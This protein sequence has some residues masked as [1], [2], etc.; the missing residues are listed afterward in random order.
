MSTFKVWVHIEEIDD[1][2][3]PK[4]DVGLPEFLGDFDELEDA[5]SFVS[6][7]FDEKT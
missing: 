6:L 1:D 3:E 7:L 2:G 5:E 4:G